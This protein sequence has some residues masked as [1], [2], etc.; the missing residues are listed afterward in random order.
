MEKDKAVKIV[1]AFVCDEL[2]SAHAG[3]DHDCELVEA[4]ARLLPRK[5]GPQLL[6]RVVTHG[7]DED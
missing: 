2:A 1:R 7:H 3:H 6:A 5:L 4:L